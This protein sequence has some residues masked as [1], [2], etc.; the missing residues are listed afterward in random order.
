[1]SDARLP[2][3][4]VILEPFAKEWC[5]GSES[6]RWARRM[7]GTMEEMQA[8]YDVAFPRLQDALAYCDRYPL[9]DLPAEVE[10]LLQLVYSTIMVAM[11]VEIWH[12]ANVIDAAGAALDRVGE[13]TP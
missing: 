8:L 4:F 6:E 10:R 2:A 9:D 13:P 3:E 11:S 12:Q 1:V 7:S 5:L